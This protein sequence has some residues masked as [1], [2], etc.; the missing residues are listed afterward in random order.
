MSDNTESKGRFAIL[1]SFMLAMS[2][3]IIP[4][5]D[6]LSLLRPDWTTLFLI[7]WCLSIPNRVAVFSGFSVGLITDH[8]TGTL[9]GQ[10]AL[11]CSFIAY[12]TISLQFR[13]KNQPIWQQALFVGMLLTI[14]RLLMHWILGM[15][16]QPPNLFVYLLAALTGALVWPLVSA[17]LTSFKRRYAIN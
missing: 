11:A 7:Y 10:H 9:L 13:I 16:S 14:H 2:L 3:L 15:T 8:L 5:P 17:L 6:K 12:L 4:L 1:F